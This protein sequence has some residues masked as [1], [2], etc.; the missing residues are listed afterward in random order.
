MDKRRTILYDFVFYLKM[1]R[2]F[3]DQREN[4]REILITSSWRHQTWPGSEKRIQLIYLTS[5]EK[6]IQ[7]CSSLKKSTLGKKYLNHAL[8]STI[9]LCWNEKSVCFWRFLG[10][11]WCGCENWR[12]WGLLL[13]WTCFLGSIVIS[14][15][16]SCW[17]SLKKIHHIY[18]GSIQ[19]DRGWNIFQS[20]SMFTIVN[21]RIHFR[22]TF[23]SEY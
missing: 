1:G 3:P 22:F 11:C 20:T 2:I 9:W 23:Q 14:I 13:F 19:R 5:F 17:L 7:N 6:I 15:D 12:F 10:R 8:N 21:G 18:I 4:T 16:V